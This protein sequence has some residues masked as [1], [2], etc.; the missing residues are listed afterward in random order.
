[1]CEPPAW[2][3]V[4]DVATIGQAIGALE[5]QLF[6][7]RERELAVF[8][9]WLTSSSAPTEILAI[10]GPGGVGKTALLGAFRRLAALEQRPIV[11]VDG[12]HQR[13]IQKALLAA[14]GGGSLDA[15]A[16]QL[17]RSKAVLLFDSF[18]QLADLGPYV[19]DCLLPR[20]D[21]QVRIVI[22]SRQPLSLLW[23][24]DDV[25]HKLVRN[26]PLDRLTRTESR[27]YLERR[28][29]ADRP[30][31]VAQILA[32]TLGYPLGLSLA[33]DL[34]VRLD[35]NSLD[36]APEWHL[37]VRSLLERLHDEIDPDVRELLECA[38]IVREFDEATLLAIAGRT[39]DPLAF[40]RICGL[41]IVRPTASG[42][43]LHEDVR[44]LLAEDLRWR[45]AQ[46]F[47]TLRHRAL[48]YCR[49][50]AH[51][52][53]DSPERARLI[54]N[55]FYLSEQPAVHTAL[56]EE[57]SPG[58]LTVEAARK[59]DHAAIRSHWRDEL[60]P[61]LLNYP[62]ARVRVAREH[63]EIIG[64]A[65]AL[66]LSRD[67][68]DVIQLSPVV[69]NVVG[70][71]LT[72]VQLKLPDT[73]ETTQLYWHVQSIRDQPARASTIAALLRDSIQL[74][75]EGGVHLAVASMSQHRAALEALRFEPIALVNGPACDVD[76][77]MTGYVLDL[78]HNG[79]DPW[80]EAVATGSDSICP[81]DADALE[82]ELQGVLAH[83]RDDEWFRRSTARQT[84]TRGAA[85]GQV[86]PSSV[87]DQVQTALSRLIDEGDADQQLAGR[88]LELAYLTPRVSHAAAME[89][90]AVSRA[91]FYR[92][93]KRGVQS[94]A[95]VMLTSETD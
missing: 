53:S 65:A 51:V 13:P 84:R 12:Q 36:A 71:Y 72:N 66:P 95:S 70:T 4:E 7:G 40:A 25:W 68:L 5:E 46:R 35:I 37:V 2:T 17:S 50:R 74:F 44:H 29:L 31:L 18:E 62:R 27:T 93:L 8:R 54:T 3:A 24:R 22:A 79:V 73:V 38:A 42:L 19:R 15:V 33:A 91:T 90:L 41:S 58:I 23:P 67:S 6:V 81:P 30:L 85:G 59:E 86:E 88:A 32:A 76:G 47:A 61:G 83:W 94:L 1:M 55:R 75:A 64:Y 48:A 78:R 60:L 63:Q 34:A 87:R 14:L 57:E 80:L 89:R 39:G 20:L 49:E 11:A 92:L 26:L 69:E 9:R 43:T 10:C 16:A 82:S 77:S 28:G 45:D 21:A 56:F 52:S